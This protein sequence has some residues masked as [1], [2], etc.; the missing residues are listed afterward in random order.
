MIDTLAKSFID[1]FYSLERSLFRGSVPCSTVQFTS[2]HSGEGVTSI[3]LAFARFLT[4]L[5]GGDSVVADEANMREPSFHELLDIP[6]ENNLRAVLS[7]AS[8][9]DE[10]VQVSKK[11]GFHCLPAG[12]SQS[13]TDPPSYAT[14]LQNLG[15]AVLPELQNRFKHVLVDSP[16]AVPFIDSS[17]ICRMVRGVVVIVQ[18][19]LTRSEVVRHTLDKL[20]S[21]QANIVGTI[22]NKREL[23]IPRWLYRFL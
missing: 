14:L 4:T 12:P 8:K 23:H 16:P 1:E 22:L 11:Y 3:T 15:E 9:V 6:C 20:Q 10:T 13:A 21:G 7:G 5:H 17:I 2:S 18:S 19:N